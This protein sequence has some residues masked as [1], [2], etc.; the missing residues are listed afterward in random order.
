MAMFNSYVS[1]PEGNPSTNDF[2]AWV[3][4]S[5][6]GGAYVYHIKPSHYHHIS[7]RRRQHKHGCGYMLFSAYSCSWHG[8]CIYAYVCDLYIYIIY[9]TYNNYNIYIYVS[10]ATAADS[11]IIL[12][13]TCVCHSWLSANIKDWDSVPSG[14]KWLLGKMIFFLNMVIFYSKLLKFPQGISH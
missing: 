10:T 12:N 6:S 4:P 11:P 2:P 14:G 5:T 1:L 13:C 8:A 3:V 9:N 7:V